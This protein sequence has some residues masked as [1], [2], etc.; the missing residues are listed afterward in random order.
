[1]SLEEILMIL[2]GRSGFRHDDIWIEY[3]LRPIG[4][5][6]R[7]FTSEYKRTRMIIWEEL[8]SMAAPFKMLDHWEATAID[9]LRRKA[10]KT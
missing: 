7:A 6:L 8:E 3:A 5:E 4:V 1:M 10:S 9:E 2:G